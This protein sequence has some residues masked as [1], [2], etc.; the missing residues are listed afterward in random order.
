MP[1]TT[2]K[3]LL[4]TIY[5]AFSLIAIIDIPENIQVLDVLLSEE[6]L[7]KPERHWLKILLDLGKLLI[8]TVLIYNYKNE[9]NRQTKP[10][11]YL[12]LIIAPVFLY[13]DLPIHA[14]YNGNLE[15]YW[16]IGRHFH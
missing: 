1:S 13:F 15:S 3:H 16:E 8:V 2:L 9:L 7:I 11:F 6:H 5:S 10:T 14:C 12:A 4:I